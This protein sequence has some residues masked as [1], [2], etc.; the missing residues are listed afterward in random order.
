MS[1]KITK[2][3]RDRAYHVQMA[4]LAE[5]NRVCKLSDEELRRRQEE[6]QDACYGE[7]DEKGD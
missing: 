6:I 3:D 1:R 7:D 2:G 4:A 5:E